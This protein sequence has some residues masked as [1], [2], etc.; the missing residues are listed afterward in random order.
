MSLFS[1]PAPQW[2]APK[3]VSFLDIARAVLVLDGDGFYRFY[4]GVPATHYFEESAGITQV[5]TSTS[6]PMRIAW[7]PTTNVIRIY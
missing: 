1:N 6:T 4:E 5:V 7:V 3:G 2:T